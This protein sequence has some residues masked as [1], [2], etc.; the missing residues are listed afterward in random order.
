MP[1]TIPLNKL[2][3]SPRNV[4]KTNGEEDI[5]SLADS[6]AAKGLLQNLV[7][8]EAPGE[9]GLYEVDAGGR[10]YRA[11]QLLVKRKEIK[12]DFP[13]P[14]LVVPREDAT[15]ASLAEN[16][17]KIAMNPADEVDAF[18][19]IIERYAESGIEAP[20]EQIANCARRFGVTVRHVRQRLRLAAL[21]PEILQ[22]LR[23]GRISLDAARAYASNPDP[24]AQLK[25]FTAE[26]KQAGKS[27]AHG[28]QAIRNALAAGTYPPTHPR[29]RYV[30]IE[31]YVAAGGRLEPDLFFGKD[32]D[33]DLIMD[34]SI[35]DRLA[36][37]KAASEADALA[38]EQGW[39]GGMFK[40]DAY[41]H[42]L[43]KAPDG[44]EVRHWGAS[45]LPPEKRQESIALYQLGAE[46]RL[47]VAEQC[48]VKATPLPER[49]QVPAEPI[50]SW[51]D[52]QRRQ[53]IRELAARLATPAVA[54]TPLEGR[55]FWP[56]DLGELVEEDEEHIVITL[57]IR[58]PKDEAEAKMA[59]AEATYER[60]RAEEDAANAVEEI[61]ISI[62]RIVSSAE[63]VADGPQGGAEAVAEEVAA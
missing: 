50:E 26:E 59:E 37:E 2:I 51:Q 52:R 38:Q 23:E 54:G 48:F 43:P 41:T 32:D 42:S 27:W 58:V 9:R 30:G 20:E 33:D 53:E 12:R 24:T 3:L 13:V 22:A 56:M 17:Q 6:I 5:E 35:I 16:L 39:A 49:R 8:S 31:A 15:E 60:R 10:R 47:Q 34:P 46:G 55:A 36:Y 14:V 11:L 62:G 63:E 19:A 7:V 4:R 1:D 44:F 25:V 29:V 28:A 21:A 57:L 40:A 18:A 45:Q 61:A